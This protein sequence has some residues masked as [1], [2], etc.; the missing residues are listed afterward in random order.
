[1]EGEHVAALAQQAV[2]QV[3]QHRY[4]FAPVLAA[5]LA[6]DDAHAAQAR[7]DRFGQEAGQQGLGLQRVG[8]VQVQFVL[9]GELAAMQALYGDF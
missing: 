9:C 1:M 7:A 5:A 4:A 6:M 3:L 2:D 8:A